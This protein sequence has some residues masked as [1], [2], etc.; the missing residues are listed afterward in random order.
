MV[1]PLNWDASY[2]IAKAL[3]ALHPNVDLADVSLDMIYRWTISLP[4]FED[5]PELSN[6]D[7]LLDIYQNWL[8]EILD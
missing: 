2:A 8:E 3:Q 6:E 1:D 4:E 7:I 5:D